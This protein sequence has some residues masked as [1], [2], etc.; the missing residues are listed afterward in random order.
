MP[1]FYEIARQRVAERAILVA[2]NVA[3]HDG[4]DPEESLAELKSLAESAGATVVNSVVQNRHRIDP[5]YFVGSGKIKQIQE[6]CQRENANLIIFDDDLSPAQIRNIEETTQIR[7]IDRSVLILDIFAA[8]ARTREAKTQVELAQLKYLFP[9]LTGRWSHLE[10]QVGGIG[11]R[12]PGEQQLEMDRRQIRKRIGNLEKI[13]VKI[14]NQRTVQRQRRESF[15]RL[16]LVGY[17]NAGK[18][19]LFN[20]LTAAGVSVEDRLFS[21]LDSTTRLVKLSGA[22]KIVITDTVGFIRKL[23]PHLVASFRSTLAEVLNAQLLLH[24]VDLS[25]P[26]FLHQIEQVQK[27]LISLGGD[28]IP[29]IMVL[30][31][32]DRLQ[33]G[34]PFADLQSL[35]DPQFLISAEQKVGLVPLL[36]TIA[37]Q[38]RLQSDHF[39]NH[40][41]NYFVTP[42]SPTNP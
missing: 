5:A 23:P 11:V 30:N 28:T 27:V 26:H 41:N 40:S 8:R 12:G 19:T 18:S 24:V 15:F 7:V 14:D 6:F 29:T 16:A 35:G 37:T 38:A 22:P 3:G 39:S 9:R 4:I 31:K 10:R 42:S 1:Q 25:T 13:L 21:T 33:T 20:R 17:T 36:D 2:A 32:I 34:I